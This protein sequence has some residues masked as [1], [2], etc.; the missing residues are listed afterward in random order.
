MCLHPNK[1]QE[2]CFKLDAKKSSITSSL[3]PM[4]R[5][6]LT[7]DSSSFMETQAQGKLTPWDF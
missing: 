5:T 6:W 4:K 2:K 1:D 7:M 3:K